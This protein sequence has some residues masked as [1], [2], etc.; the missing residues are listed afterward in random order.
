MPSV[1]DYINGAG[2]TTGEVGCRIVRGGGVVDEQWA[3]GQFT[4]ISCEKWR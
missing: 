3:S 2:N 1:D 4:N